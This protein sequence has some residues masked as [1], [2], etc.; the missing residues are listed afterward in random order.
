[1]NYVARRGRARIHWDDALASLGRL[2]GALAARWRRPRQLA[3]SAAA[4]AAEWVSHWRDLLDRCGWPGDESESLSATEFAARNAWEECSRNS[5]ASARSHAINRQYRVGAGS[6][7]ARA[8]IFQPKTPA[9]RSRSSA[10]WKPRACRST[11]CGLPGCRHSAAAGAAAQCL[12]ADCMAA[13]SQR[14]RSRASRELAYA[15]GDRMLV[16][17]APRVVLSYPETADG[18]P[19][20]P[21]R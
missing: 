7:P 8:T 12:P 17:G 14:P 5:R 18:E 6:Q 2:D 15:R 9:R 21:R 16:Q 10:S 20:A 11:R 13:R 4:V 1:V 3:S 19:C